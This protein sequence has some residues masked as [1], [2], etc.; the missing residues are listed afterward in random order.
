MQAPVERARFGHTKQ[1]LVYSRTQRA[2]QGRRGG[3]GRAKSGV[4]GLLGM[5]V[6]LLYYS[7]LYCALLC[8]IVLS[9]AFLYSP[10]RCAA[11][12]DCLIDYL[13]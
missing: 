12:P 7:L 13:T 11:L 5:W 8:S 3:A 1:L 2:G 4:L 9:F 6:S 10:L